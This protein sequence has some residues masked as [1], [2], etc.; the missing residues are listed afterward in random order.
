MFNIVGIEFHIEV[1]CL[2]QFSNHL[3]IE[4]NPYMLSMFQ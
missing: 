2:Q 3:K 4:K 1:V